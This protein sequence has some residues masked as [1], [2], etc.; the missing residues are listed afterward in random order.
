MKGN[1]KIVTGVTLASVLMLSSCNKQNQMQ[2]P[3]VKFKTEKVSKKNVTLE[4]SYTA[5][6]RGQQDIEVYPQ[7]SGTLQK[8]Y[9]TEGQKVKKGQPLFVIDQVP[10]QAA[11]NT[12]EATLKA[13]RAQEATSKLNLDSRQELFDKKVVSEYDLKTAEN[14]WLSAKASVAQ[15]EAQLINAKNSL[16]YTVVKSPSDGVVGTLPYR[17]GALVGPTL[18][19][20]LTT[21]SDNDKMYVYFSITESQLLQLSRKYGSMEQAIDSMPDV[22]LK[23]VDG[24]IYELSGRIESASGVIDRATGTAQFRAE[25]ANPSHILLSGSTGKIT[26]PIEYKDVLT[27]PTTA[28]VQMQDRYKVYVVDNNGVAHSQLVTLNPQ[29]NGKEVIVTEGLNGGEEIVAEGA[30]MVKEGQTVK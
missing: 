14:T 16:S 11:V 28:T 4:S 5:T 1:L 7:V 13:A 24:T 22:H 20:P 25:F 9:V 26:M 23:L 29:S 15:A 18:P 27:I 8:L 17:L 21:I 10:Y 12:S 2:M 6:I 3:T 30:G 19:Q